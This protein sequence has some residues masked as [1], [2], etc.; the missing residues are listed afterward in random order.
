MQQAVVGV[1]P[2]SPPREFYEVG[3]RI[4]VKEREGIPSKL[5]GI[6]RF[7]DRPVDGV[8]VS[9][10]FQ[11][12]ASKFMLQEFGAIAVVPDRRVQFK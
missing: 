5:I 11:N 3:C 10:M 1:N 4:A 8:S 2:Q 7:P 12:R 9:P 6:S